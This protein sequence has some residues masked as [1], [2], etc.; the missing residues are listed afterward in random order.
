[1]PPLD[2][3][4]PRHRPGRPGPLPRFAPVACLEGQARVIAAGHLF[5]VGAVACVLTLTA[6][7]C[8]GGGDAHVRTATVGRAT[9]VEIVE[10]PSVVTARASAT[11][12]APAD[13]TV[14]SLR[15]REGQRVRAGQ[16]L[17]R[18]GSPDAH[19]RS[20]RCGNDALVF[21]LLRLGPRLL[22]GAPPP[23]ARGRSS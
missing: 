4:N 14:G 16:V 22:G 19:R 2:A 7:G 11:V 20:G 18:V 6:A 3:C 13:G 15:A 23:R 9:V 12:T 10:A 5:R 17:L 1:M 21:G 8:V